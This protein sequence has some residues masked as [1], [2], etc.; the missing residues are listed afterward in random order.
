M[1]Y[2]LRSIRLPPLC[3]YFHGGVEFWGLICDIS[4]LLIE[5]QAISSLTGPRPPRAAYRNS[6][7]ILLDWAPAP[8]MGAYRTLRAGRSPHYN[9]DRKSMIY[10]CL[11]SSLQ[12]HQ[13]AIATNTRGLQIRFSFLKVLLRTR[14][15]NLSPFWVPVWCWCWCWCWC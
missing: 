14:G 7:H 4:Y 3:T 5:T 1:L 10:I 9:S 8:D 15:P 2:W 6:S 11:Y 12:G 13:R